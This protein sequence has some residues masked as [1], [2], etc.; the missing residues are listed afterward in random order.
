MYAAR[1][2][3]GRHHTGRPVVRKRNKQLQNKGND[4][5]YW[6]Y[7]LTEAYRVSRRPPC[8]RIIRAYGGTGHTYRYA[9]PFDKNHS[10]GF[11]PDLQRSKRKKRSACAKP[12]TCSG[13][14][15]AVIQFLEKV[16]R[17]SVYNCMSVSCSLRLFALKHDY[18]D[19]Q[20]SLSA[21]NKSFY[22]TLRSQIFR[23]ERRSKIAKL[24]IMLP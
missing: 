20:H 17:P 13:H 5:T 9:V 19:L 16:I 14:P 2:E 11:L 3:Q 23:F 1:G 24:G 8:R 18:F 7:G 15:S 6:E 22:S 4:G 12:Y 10:F 21:Y